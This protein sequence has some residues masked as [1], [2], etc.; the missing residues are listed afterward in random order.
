MKHKLVVALIVVFST[1]ALRAADTRTMTEHKN[2]ETIHRMFEE[3]FNSG[4]TGLDAF[5]DADYIGAGDRRGPIAFAPPVLKLLR[6]FPDI[7]YTIEDLIAE[8]DRVTVRWTWTGTHRGEFNGI[9]PTGKS[10]TNEGVAIFQ[11]RDAKII[12][13]WTLT[14]RL[15]FLQS[16]GVVPID[17]VPQPATPGR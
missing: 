5:V 13:S 15:G 11:L 16:V 12:R 4:L 14:D 3:S 6:A 8:G 10:V 2:K 17:V 1:T 7:H 9:Q